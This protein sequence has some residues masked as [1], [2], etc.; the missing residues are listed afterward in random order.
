MK[1]LKNIVIVAI[2][3]VF[4]FLLGFFI[5]FHVLPIHITGEQ[6]GSLADWVSA[7]GTLGAVIIALIVR[8]D[9]FR[10][11]KAKFLGQYYRKLIFE[12]AMRDEILN[13]YDNIANTIKL[14]NISVSNNKPSFLVK[15]LT[16]QL[17]GLLVC[18]TKLK[19]FDFLYEEELVKEV[20]Q[21][22]SVI[23][24]YLKRDTVSLKEVKTLRNQLMNMF[25]NLSKP[26]KDEVK[27]VNEKIDI[28]QQA[29]KD[30]GLKDNQIIPDSED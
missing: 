24:D 1:L 26:V 30:F 3:M 12:K 15:D 11:R 5:K 10:N 14:F 6:S 23:K 4:G 20:D 19:S 16:K 22:I 13:C 25:L 28:F 29:K 2:G 8:N 7:L 27:Y 18:L 9:V 21:N 17:K